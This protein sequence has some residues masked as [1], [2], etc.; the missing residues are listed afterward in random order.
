MLRDYPN[1]ECKVFVMKETG[2]QSALKNNFST[3]GGL[4]G[5]PASNFS[6]FSLS[7]EPLWFSNSVLLPYESTARREGESG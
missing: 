5:K 1:R 4:Y 6:S 7:Q 3:K 2:A